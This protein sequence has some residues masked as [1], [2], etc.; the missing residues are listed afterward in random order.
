MPSRGLRKQSYAE[1]FKA[2]RIGPICTTV[3]LRPTVVELP[4]D[5]RSDEEMNANIITLRLDEKTLRR[6]KHLAM[7]RNISVSD[8]VRKLVERAVAELD[9]FEAAR[10]DALEALN[11][12]APVTEGLLGREQ[13]RER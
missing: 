8:L 12:P 9:E 3:A 11:H 13:A 6:V 1:P 2:T 10:A 7:D 5:L 4:I